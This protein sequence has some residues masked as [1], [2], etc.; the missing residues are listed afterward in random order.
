MLHCGDRGFFPQ[1]GIVTNRDHPGHGRGLSLQR[2]LV[3]ASAAGRWGGLAEGWFGG[4]GRGRDRAAE[5]EGPERVAV[6]REIE[7]TAS[8]DDRDVLLA[9]HFVRDGRGVGACAGLE[10]PEFVAVLMSYATRRPSDSP[11]KIR[12][13]AVLSR[14]LPAAIGN[15]M[16]FCQTILLVAGL[17]AVRVPERGSLVG[18]TNPPPSVKSAFV[19]APGT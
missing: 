17:I 4:G 1:L 11:W 8:R 19:I 6:L 15:F 5:F 13:E 7:R 14:P 16:R 9:F 3:S 10:G 18:R 12:P 2:P